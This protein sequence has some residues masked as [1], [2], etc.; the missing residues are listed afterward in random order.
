MRGRCA[1][2]AVDDDV[3][4]I[5]RVYGESSVLSVV[6]R[7]GSAK[8]VAV[9]NALFAEGECSGLVDFGGALYVDAFSGKSFRAGGGDE[10]TLLLDIEPLGGLM[11]ISIT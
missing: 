5:L 2:C 4:A 10:K 7:S 3:A 11:L 8:R 6:N 1:V 9:T